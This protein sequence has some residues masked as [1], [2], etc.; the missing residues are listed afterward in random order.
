MSQKI[1]LVT[2]EAEKNDLLESYLLENSYTVSRSVLADNKIQESILV[3]RP[4]VVII[5]I[6]KAEESI[7]STIQ[8]IQQNTPLPIIIFA[9]RSKDKLIAE[10]ITAGASGF[11]I[12]GVEKHRICPIIEVATA[13]F[14]KC[15][16]IKIK[17]TETE[18]KLNERKDIDR[19]KGILMSKK[20]IKEDEA[21]QLLRKMAM[22][23]NVRMGEL[24]K[25]II[26]A[27]ELL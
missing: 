11:V 10:A 15:Q 2:N 26:T 16:S 23:K 21:Y 24:A 20:S 5:Y 19:A 9:Q 12:D 6:E 22:D 3:M 1:L 17:L 25:T 14:N 18:L 27:S 7:L 13:R 8:L 4:D